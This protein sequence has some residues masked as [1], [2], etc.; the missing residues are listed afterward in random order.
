LESLIRLSQ[1]H[2]R[3]LYR[4]NVTLQDAVAIL[5]VMECTAYAYGGFDGS[6]D[7]FEN[8]MYCD[9]MTVDF[10]PE[11]DL[12]MLCFEYRILE[13]YGMLSFIDDDRRRK[14]MAALGTTA[15]GNGADSSGWHG[16]E[17]PRD[18]QWQGG[19]S[20]TGDASNAQPWSGVQQYGGGP[21]WP[22]PAPGPSPSVTQDHYGRIHFSTPGSQSQNKRPR[23]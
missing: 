21:E 19:P 18:R 17:N 9:P 2:A 5:Q 16:A 22:A 20:G 4:K 1:A 6:V 11:A 23:R 3:L 14:A 8:A 7:D 15:S 10:S 13:R 12:D